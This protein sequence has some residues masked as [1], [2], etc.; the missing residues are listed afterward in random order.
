MKK[1]IRENQALNSNILAFD[2]INHKPYVIDLNVKKPVGPSGDVMQGA[3]YQDYPA[4]RTLDD[5][6]IEISYLAPDAKSVR[7]KGIIGAFLP[8]WDMVKCDDGFWRV[9]IP[10]LTP[11][12]HYV[13]FFVDGVN[14]LNPFMPIGF[15][16]SKAM[17]YLEIANPDADF[18]LLK[19]VPHGT[20]H[21]EIIWLETAQR[22]VNAWVYT[23]ASY[24][25][26]PGK[27]YPVMYI[28][29]GGGEDEIAWFFQGKLNYIADNLIAAGEAE[30][31]IIVCASSYLVRR[32]EDGLVENLDYTESLVSEIIPYIDGHYRTIADRVYRAAAGLSL[33]G[34]FARSMAHRHPETFASLGQFSSG[35]CFGTVCNGLGGPEDFSALFEDP[36]KFNET[37]KLTFVTC[38]TDDPRHVTTSGQCADWVAKGF[39]VE[40]ACYPGHHEWNP[41]RESVRDYMKRVFKW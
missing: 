25:E 22:Y 36:A 28:Q 3:I 4:Y 2:P 31:M 39:N 26:N 23:P 37:Y 1:E 11:G 38:G 17:N 27:R 9:T 8:G 7:I 10:G 14:A 15:G 24:N 16:G 19:N 6:S 5:G 13:E 29:H 41:W 18:Y 32:H 21:M 30:E 20:L 40:Y 33:G 12:F 35:S 34:A